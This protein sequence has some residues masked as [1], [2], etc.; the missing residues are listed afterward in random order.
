M[1]LYKPKTIKEAIKDL[2]QFLECDLYTKFRPIEKIKGKRW[3]RKDYFRN[4]GEFIKYIE[5]HFD[6][7]LKQVK[8]LNLQTNK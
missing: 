7:L 5:E 4:E 3:C 8:R 6:L 2:R 1:K